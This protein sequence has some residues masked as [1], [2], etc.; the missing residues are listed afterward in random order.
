[1]FISLPKNV[2]PQEITNSDF[3]IRKYGLL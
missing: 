2:N 3:G 1:M